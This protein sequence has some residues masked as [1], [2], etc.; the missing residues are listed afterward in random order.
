MQI[1]TSMGGASEREIMRRHGV[2][3]LYGPGRQ[4]PAA[5]MR[6]MP[7]ALDNGAFGAWRRNRPFDEFGFL[8]ALHYMMDMNVNP[9]FIVAP[10]IV[11]RGTQSLAF[12]RRWAERLTYPTSLA[13]AVQ[14]G[15]TPETVAPAMDEFGWG[16]FI[17]GSVDWKW[18]TLDAWIEFARSLGKKCHVGRCGELEQLLLAHERG[19]TSAD[20]SSFVRNKSWEIVA[21]FNRCVK[22]EGMQ[23]NLFKEAV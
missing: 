17:G 7:T 4:L 3:V 11:S 21:E 1:Y 5:D 18:A 2:G 9:E 16:I 10:D 22:G 19:A 23:M 13:L 20:S 15:M 14:D 6:A 8:K 12:S